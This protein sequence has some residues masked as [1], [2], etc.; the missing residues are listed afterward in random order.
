[1]RMF[2]QMLGNVFSILLTLLDA[3]RQKV[4]NLAVNGAEIIFCPRRNRI[5]QFFIQPQRYL[6]LGHVVVLPPV[7]R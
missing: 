5:I 7:L 3:F 1:M 4:F 6:L 2:I